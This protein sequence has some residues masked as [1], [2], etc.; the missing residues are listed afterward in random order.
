MENRRQGKQKNASFDGL[1][2]NQSRL[3]GSLFAKECTKIDSVTCRSPESLG[4]VLGIGG[5]PFEIMLS[6]MTPVQLAVSH[7]PTSKEMAPNSER[8]FMKVDC[9]SPIAN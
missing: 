7:S 3:I 5:I 9:S 6:F 1:Q 8:A 4:N 2:V